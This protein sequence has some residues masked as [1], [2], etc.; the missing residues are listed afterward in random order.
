MNI[1][2]VIVNVSCYLCFLYVSCVREL[3][4]YESHC[5]NVVFEHLFVNA[6]CVNQYGRPANQRAKECHEHIQMFFL[7]YNHSCDESDEANYQF[8]DA[9]H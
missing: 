3:H 4:A 7:S 9:P 1:V 8:H 2:H 6:Q 5:I